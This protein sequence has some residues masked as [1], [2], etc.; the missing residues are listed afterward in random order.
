[1][2]NGTDLAEALATLLGEILDI[3]VHPYPPDTFLPP[4][5]VV[6][7]PTLSWETDNRTFT[8]IQWTFP[9]TLAVARPTEREAQMELLRMVEAVGDV[10][11]ES[12]D[13][14]GLAQSTR[15]MSAAPAQVTASG[16]DY[17]AYLCSAEIIA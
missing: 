3:R 4:G 17:P 1:V 5:A 13:L 16:I 11:A 2:I 10:L 6:G 12:A 7:Q 15:L 8:A 14:G 9:I